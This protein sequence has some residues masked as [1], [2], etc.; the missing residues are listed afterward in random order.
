MTSSAQI[1][2]TPDKIYGQLFT[3][4]QLA[5]IFP[6]AKTFVDCVPKRN[7]KLIVADYLKI[8]NNPAIRFS[9]KRF[10]EENFELPSPPQLNYVTKET[11]V[12]E[13]INNLWSVLKREKDKT[14]TGSSLLPLPNSYI[15]PGGRFHEIYYWDSY[16]TM[17]GLK[18]SGEYE[19]IENMVRNFAYLINTFG[20]VPNGNRSYYLSRSQ[21]PY[22]SFMVKLLADIK[23]EQVYKEFLPALQKEYD[24]W[25]L[26]ASTVKVGQAFK[27]VVK[28]NDGTVLNRYWDEHT[29]ARQESYREDVETADEAV[30]QM[31][32]S[33]TFLNDKTAEV[34]AKKLRLKVYRDLR[35]GAASGW[36][37]S[38]RWLADGKHLSTIQ[39]TDILPVDLNCLL[40]NLEYT[41]ELA[42]KITG[43][44][45]LRKRYNTLAYKREQSFSNV[46]SCPELHYFSD[47]NF[48]TKKP[49]GIAAASSLMIASYLLN[50]NPEGKIGLGNA[51]AAFIKKHLLKEGGIVST[52]ESTTQQWDSPNGWAPLQW[53]A[54]NALERTEQHDLA[55]E[56]ALR[57]IK[58]NKEVFARTGKLMEKYNVVDTHLEAGGGEY[59]G[60]D[61]FGWTNGVYL[62]LMNKY[63]VD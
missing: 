29:T 8:K 26:G 31:L 34:A 36:D 44:E 48:K 11:D 22:F 20:H 50:Q 30:R 28:L 38:S 43:K 39:T 18:E 47:Y 57:W 3:D 49:T 53:I 63:K 51:T 61:G 7:P 58:L 33:T 10:V 46:F 54:V 15:V 5:R 9:L 16:F 19:L 6:D 60:Q 37:F 41:L 45:N 40:L 32:A 1:I 52:A 24:Y 23:G 27:S 59:A 4:V 12:K 14:I 62:A 25:M 21:P 2:S 13:H 56:I 35:A 17:L 42:Y 55:K